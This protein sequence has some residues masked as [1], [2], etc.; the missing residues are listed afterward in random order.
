MSRK[1]K[2]KGFL[3]VAPLTLDFSIPCHSQKRWQRRHFTLYDDGELQYALDNNSETIPQMIMDMNRC[4]R[5]C[6][7]DSITG[8]MHS[9]L[10]AFKN[11]NCEDYGSEDYQ[12]PE[13]ISNKSDPSHPAVCYVKADCTEEIRWWQS[14]L[15]TFAQQNV[16]HCIPRKNSGDE[17]TLTTYEPTIIQVNAQDSV[18]EPNT[19][20]SSR[21]SSIERE[22][23]QNVHYI[24]NNL[25]ENK[26]HPSF[27]RQDSIDGVA[28]SVVSIDRHSSVS[29]QESFKQPE[30]TIHGTPRAVKQRKRLTRDEI[31]LP[32][33]KS[34]DSEFVNPNSNC[35]VDKFDSV[36]VNKMPLNSLTTASCNIDTTNAH[37]VRK[38]WLTLRGK[39]DK[40]SNKYWVVLAGLSLKLYND[41]WTEGTS[42]PEVTID[43]TDCENVYPSAS[44]K[45]Y[46][47]EIKC[48]RQ[49]YVLLAITPGIRDSWA[50]CLQ[51]NLNNP[52]PTFVDNS[53]QSVDALSQCDSADVMSQP[54]RK[55]HIA[56]VAPESHH[57][58]SMRGDDDMDE[59]EIS[60]MFEENNE[61]KNINTLKGQLADT[62]E[63]LN[64]T[65]MENE[66]LRDL[67]ANSNASNQLAHLRKCLTVAETDI[68][69]KQEEMEELREQLGN[70][71]NKIVIE[72]RTRM[73]NL[74]RLQVTSLSKILLSAEGHQWFSL[75][76][77]ADNIMRNVAPLDIDD[78][79]VD[80]KLESIFQN[81]SQAYGMLNDLI[82]GKNDVR[83]K[84]VNTD[85]PF[86]NSGDE[87]ALYAE[88]EELEGELEEIQKI[89]NDELTEISKEFESKMRQFKQR[90]DNEE[91]TKR[92]LQDELQALLN[93][94]ES[95]S[96][97]ALSRTYDEKMAM[98]TS[99]FDKEIDK[100]KNQHAL[101]L[102]D[103]QEATKLAL[104]VV[105]RTH[106]EELDMLNE[107]LEKALHKLQQPLKECPSFD[108]SHTT[109]LINQMSSE[110]Q[111]LSSLYSSKC[112]EN[113]QLDEKLL[114][115]EKECS[116][117]ADIE[118]HNKKLIREIQQRD[119]T[120]DGLKIKVSI[121][122][123]KLIQMGENPA[124]VS[125]E[126]RTEQD[127]AQEIPHSPA[128]LTSIA[129][130]ETSQESEANCR[131]RFRQA[132]QRR[133]DVRYHSNPAIPV[134]SNTSTTDK[135][136]FK[137]RQCN[138]MSV[139]D[140]K[141]LFE[142]VA[143][144]TTPF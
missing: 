68:I 76:Q 83:E 85:G 131:V 135:D 57:S 86:Q 106:D 20:S 42:T 88:I 95:H 123:K 27:I 118:M 8:N 72:A 34:T 18:S 50:Q 80:N 59:E 60:S 25:T 79:D 81:I 5:V 104:D 10:I 87:A 41:V 75:K 84:G 30:P 39:N 21:D 140:R 105:K 125:Q 54:R 110:I 36:I 2:A 132:H 40:E 126:E 49:R 90:L 64:F 117:L 66:K 22:A 119:Q 99:E 1:L 102:E 130:L 13:D 144:Y 121:L 47:I 28:E 74:A 103:E 82:G 139:N 138:A 124:I 55:K 107:K 89:H 113:S 100:L 120:A 101:D 67:F 3:Y 19:P 58:N 69:K 143:E 45:Y 44:A 14:M 51:Q 65:Q 112:F 77:C 111:N 108:D 46:G 109:A 92:K 141:K 7:A 38:G 48:R 29:R 56:Y 63:Q 61:H 33:I 137:Q 52:S 15:Q 31:I 142:C 129:S 9:L 11:G 12:K 4:I 26:H 96:H 23:N 114:L 93:N 116:N 53:C 24:N 134:F 91:H 122:E 62:K 6:E 98:L 73:L 133:R 97:A 32:R 127:P 71:G 94:N 115:A 43:L 16:I 17:D 35:S 70:S 37:T 78:G 128:L 136:L